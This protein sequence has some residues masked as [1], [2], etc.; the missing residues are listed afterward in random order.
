MSHHPERTARNV[1]PVNQ[2]PSKI[3]D[4]LEWYL[5]SRSDGCFGANFSESIVVVFESWT[6][7][8]ASAQGG[9]RFFKVGVEMR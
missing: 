4:R 5:S 2:P 6:P 8:E 9:W 3:N 1:R 7:V